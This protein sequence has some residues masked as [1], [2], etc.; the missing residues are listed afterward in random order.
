M[1]IIPRCGHVS[2]MVVWCHTD[3]FC[4][5]VGIRITQQLTSLDLGMQHF[6]TAQNLLCGQA[7]KQYILLTESVQ[8][9]A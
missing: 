3:E 7:N 2:N 1:F 5:D 6:S 4:L 8:S 9:A